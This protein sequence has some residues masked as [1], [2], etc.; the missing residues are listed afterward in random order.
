MEVSYAY[1]FW[2]LSTIK[3]KFG[4]ILVCCMRNISNMF[5]DQCWRLETSSRPLYGFIK[6]TV[7]RDPDIFNSWHLLFLI[8]PYSH[9]QKNET[10]E[11]WHN[12]LLSNWSRLELSPSP[13]N[14]SK[15]SWKLL[16]LLIYI[17]WPRLLT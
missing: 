12:W 1:F 17:N 3:M 8:V 9:F 6:M 13:R 16:P 11:S 4:D 10:Q 2:I 7:K 14:C 5:L 15:D